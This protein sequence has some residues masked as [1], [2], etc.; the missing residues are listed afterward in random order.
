VI[1]SILLSSTLK[2]NLF[3]T[4]SQV[5]RKFRYFSFLAYLTIPPSVWFTIPKLLKMN[6]QD[7]K[8]RID[9]RDKIEHLDY[10]EQLVP[11]GK[12]IP[13]DRKQIFHLEN[14]AGQLLLASWQPLANQFYS[15]IFF[16]LQESDVHVALVEEVRAAFADSDA[17]NMETVGTLKYLP[18]CVQESL[19]LHQDTVDGL[20]RVSPGAVVDGK[21][22]PKGV[23]IAVS[24][25]NCIFVLTLV[26]TRSHVK[27]AI[28]RQQE[29]HDSS[30]IRS[31]FVLN[32]GWPRIMLD[33][34]RGIKTT[35]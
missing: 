32:D 22:I 25:V 20:P 6:T 34:I 12:P 18:A 15:L 3:L 1:D 23:S 28:S 14:I 7:V 4:M 33:T 30:Q 19:R 21:H 2:L 17:I 29:V 10:F 9:R 8:I 31:S 16:L 35:T 24:F 11:S 13:E 5:T 26:R 27:S